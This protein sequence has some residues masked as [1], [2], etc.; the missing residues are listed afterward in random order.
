[1]TPQEWAAK[2]KSYEERIKEIVI[3]PSISEQDIK[4]IIAK[5]D[6]IFS[7][8]Y[9]DYTRA[10]TAYERIQRKNKTLA[11]SLFLTAKGGGVEDLG[12]RPSDETAKA[13]AEAKLAE[14]GGDDEP[15][16]LWLEEQTTARFNFMSAVIDLLNTKRQM[17]ITDQAVLKL[18]ASLQS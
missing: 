8:A 11:K 1:M 14:M 18:E 15:N 13:W 9:F 17:V 6:A 7:D 3:S 4:E 5:L 16:P 2:E 10:K 12:P